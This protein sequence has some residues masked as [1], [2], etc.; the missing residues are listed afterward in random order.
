MPD[1]LVRL[2]AIDP[3]HAGL[4][5]YLDLDYFEDEGF[6]TWWQVLAAYL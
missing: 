2:K 6:L 5:A 4:L 1:I 3:Y